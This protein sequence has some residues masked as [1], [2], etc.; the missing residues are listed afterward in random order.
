MLAHWI[1]TCLSLH[2]SSYIIFSLSAAFQADT[3]LSWNQLACMKFILVPRDLSIR[4]TINHQKEAARLTSC[5]SGTE[6]MK[7][8]PHAIFDHNVGWMATWRGD[9]E[10]ELTER[11]VALH[12]EETLSMRR[13]A[14]AAS[15]ESEESLSRLP[16]VSSNTRNGW[17]HHFF[18]F[19]KHSKIREFCILTFWSQFF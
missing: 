7:S 10:L 19:L 17:T 8:A 9:L 5:L 18:K 4:Y 16:G 14:T 2:H 3:L 1:K 13:A 11:H 12:F 6:E 15:R